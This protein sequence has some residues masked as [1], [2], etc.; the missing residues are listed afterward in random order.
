MLINHCKI[1]GCRRKERESGKDSRENQV[2]NE[3]GLM[4]DT[5][6]EER[7]DRC[8]LLADRMGTGD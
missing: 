5:R 2:R 8:A 6:R 4:L 7:K 1:I 3:E